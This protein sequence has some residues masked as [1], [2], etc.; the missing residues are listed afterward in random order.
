M[1]VIECFSKYLET[2]PLTTTPS[3]LPY[4]S[5]QVRVIEANENIEING[6]IGTK[7]VSSDSSMKNMA[8]IK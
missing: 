6:N 7:W 2:N 8:I 5:K 3:T 4:T 1:F